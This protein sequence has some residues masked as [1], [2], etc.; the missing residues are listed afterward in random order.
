MAGIVDVERDWR[1]ATEENGRI[2]ISKSTA[3]NCNLLVVSSH[4]KGWLN[5]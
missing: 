3:G 2:D 4:G 1:H 5:R